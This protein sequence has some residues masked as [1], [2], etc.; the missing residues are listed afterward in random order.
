VPLNQRYPETSQSGIPRHARSEDPTTDHKH[1]ETL[2]REVRKIAF[3]DST[4][5]SGV[6]G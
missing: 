5:P 2:I 3:Q 6:G 4:Y 1:I